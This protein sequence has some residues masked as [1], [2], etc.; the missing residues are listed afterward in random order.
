M[1]LEESV[2]TYRD[3]I[4]N[5]DVGFYQVTL[6]GHMINHNL[7]HKTILGYDPSDSLKDR[8]VRSFW[9]FPEQRDEYID[10][11][12]KNDV[13]KDYICHS[14]TK[15]GKKIIVECKEYYTQLISRDLILIFST[16]VRD[17]MPDEAW[18]V[19][20]NDFEP[21]ALE[22]CKRYGIRSIYL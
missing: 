21:S 15:D 17:I 16:K 10:L 8:D 14:L 11:L 18:F 5:L 1:E 12:L 20:I 7:A 2:E 19:T 6:D 13:V 22:L 3:M 9:Q 4:D